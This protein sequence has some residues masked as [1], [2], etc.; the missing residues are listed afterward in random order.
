[1]DTRHLRDDEFVDWLDGALIETRAK[2]LEQCERCRA[3]SDRLRSLMGTVRAA[4]VPEPSPLYW[5]NLS[6]RV[7][8]RL[9]AEPARL[10]WWHFR[11]ITAGALRS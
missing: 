8:H 11:P 4:E 1:M 5:D 3:E 6:R 2:H 10:P 9:E 7:R